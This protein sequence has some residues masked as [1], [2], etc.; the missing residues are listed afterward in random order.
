MIGFYI[1]KH[2]EALTRPSTTRFDEYSKQR[3]KKGGYQ[4]DQKP[5]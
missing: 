1:R 5:N 2:Q 3:Q 4:Y